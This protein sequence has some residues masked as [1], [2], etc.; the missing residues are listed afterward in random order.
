VGLRFDSGAEIPDPKANTTVGMDH[1]FH[2]LG[3]LTKVC[4][5][6]IVPRDQLVEGALEQIRLHTPLD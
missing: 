6:R 2:A 1:L 4:P 3:R 5:E